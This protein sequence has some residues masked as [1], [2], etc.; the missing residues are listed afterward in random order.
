M[1]AD[2]AEQWLEISEE[3]PGYFEAVAAMEA[4]FSVDPD[5]LREVALPAFER[6]EVVLWARD[7]A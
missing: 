2:D 4:R 3:W 7:P 5:W 6:S 1:T